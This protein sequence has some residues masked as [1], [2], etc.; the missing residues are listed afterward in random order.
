MTNKI[1]DHINT[2]TEAIN[3]VKITI[4]ADTYLVDPTNVL[5]TPLLLL[6]VNIEIQE[7]VMETRM[8]KF[9]NIVHGFETLYMDL[10]KLMLAKIYTI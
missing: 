1:V 10:S 2:L 4:E 6:L 9:D 3:E 5:E 8:P 7:Q